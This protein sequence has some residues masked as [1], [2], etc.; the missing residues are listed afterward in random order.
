MDPFKPCFFELWILWVQDSWGLRTQKQIQFCRWD[1]LIQLT[2]ASLGQ[3]FLLLVGLLFSCGD[4][5]MCN[6]QN[7]PQNRDGIL[8][9]KEMLCSR[10]FVDALTVWACLRWIFWSSFMFCAYAWTLHSFT[11]SAETTKVGMAVLQDLMN[12][13]SVH[14]QIGK[15]F[16]SLV[17]NFVITSPVMLP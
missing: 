11:W 16:S 10:V 2:Q 12:V 14:L 3:W 9:W 13:W 15:P 7:S 4:Y 8:E 5:F 6:V 17:F 1:K